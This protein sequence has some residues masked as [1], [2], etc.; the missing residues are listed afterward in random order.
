[1]V[2]PD[3]LRT[4]GIVDGARARYTFFGRSDLAKLLINVPTAAVDNV[5]LRA[6][7]YCSAEVCRH[8]E[9]S[10]RVGPALPP[11]LLT[12]GMEPA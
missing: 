2:Q 12:Y 10:V 3:T 8:V 5:I 7:G 9:A 6:L 1:M 4:S 11:V